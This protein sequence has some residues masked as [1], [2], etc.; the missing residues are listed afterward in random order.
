MKSKLAQFVVVLTLA[1]SGFASELAVLQ[2][3]NSIRYEH[4][5]VMGSAT[6]L[7]TSATNE[8]YVDIP[9]SKIDHFEPDLTP[10][11]QSSPPTA[12]SLAVAVNHASEQTQLDP[13]LISSV[14][15]AESGFNPD[16]VSR[17]GAQGLMQLMPQTA[18]HLGVTNPFDPE[19]NVEGGSRYLREL[20]DRYHSNLVIALAAYNAGPQRVA[21]YN[22]V[23]PY[24]ETRAYVGSIVRDFNRKKL[25]E[26]KAARAS[27]HKPSAK[28]S[29][30]TATTV[31]IAPTEI[32]STTHP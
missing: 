26:Q 4:R 30:K 28:T 9:T 25:A 6:R 5:E 23:P 12:V 11:A 22:G 13:D 24:R 1:A 27:A 17:K 8:E 18:S 21:Q 15:H 20:L 29:A 19:A 10:A 32:S 16:A 14:I 2:N 7:Y 31:T 3:G